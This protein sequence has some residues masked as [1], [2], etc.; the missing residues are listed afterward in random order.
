MDESMIL[1]NRSAM[2]Q[3][4]RA[5]IIMMSMIRSKKLFIIFNINSVF[6]LDKN[7]ALHRADMLIHLYAVND[8]FAARG[9]Y[10]VVP[11]AKGRLKN[12]YIVGKKYYSYNKAQSAFSDHFPSY[13]PF[14]NI[15]YERRK[16][17]AIEG[18]FIENKSESTKVKD[19]RNSY[20][21]YLKK[22]LKLKNIEIAK[23]GDV[24][25]RTV[26]RALKK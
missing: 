20:I 16:Q 11:S 12:L 6:D 7:L 2:S 19:S 21:V 24:S 18:Y 1:S 22:K 9:R 14:D 23:I 15:E 26:A 8:K 25:P 10:F 17:K 13:F 4:N 5:V 3:Y